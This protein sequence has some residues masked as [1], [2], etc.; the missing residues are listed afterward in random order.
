M[1]SKKQNIDDIANDELI[2]LYLQG[3]MDDKAEAEFILK[4]KSDN[5]LRQMAITQARLVKGMRQVDDELLQA[6]KQIDESELQQILKESVKSQTKFRLL[7]IR[8]LS[9]AASV[10]ILIVSSYKGYDYYTTTRLGMSYANTFPISTI[11]R[12]DR[13]ESVD[14]ELS[15]LF[16]NVINRTDLTSTTNRLAELW[17][18]SQH[19][20]YND[21]T[22]YA[23][24]IGWYLAIGYLEDYEKEMAKKILNEMQISFH[25]DSLIIDNVNQLL[26]KI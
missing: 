6:F 12:G 15:E 18:V 7:V 14:G 23:P 24:Y 25:D 20:T 11:T 17:E 2:S 9:I 1:I 21:Y 13:N 26:D 10:V 19:E 4:L 3:K 22:D 8:W 5:S 16:N